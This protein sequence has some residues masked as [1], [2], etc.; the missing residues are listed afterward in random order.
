MVIATEWEQ[1]KQI[2]LSRVKA[3]NPNLK[4]IDLRNILDISEIKKHGFIFDFIG[5][6]S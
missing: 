3:L 5:N 2:D 4:I 1:Y 6:G